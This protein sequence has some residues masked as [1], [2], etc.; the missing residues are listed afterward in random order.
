[1]VMVLNTHSNLRP[2]A[3]KV[4]SLI[5]S[6]KTEVHILSGDSSESVEKL[7]YYLNIPQECLHPEQS[8]FDKMEWIKQIQSTGD[9]GVIM[10]GDGMLLLI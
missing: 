1:M 7:G 10:V 6:E 8:A 3:Q 9:K 4:I 5:Q 2:E